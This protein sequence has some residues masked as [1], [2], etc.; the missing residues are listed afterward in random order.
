MITN[1]FWS[2]C[3]LAI[4]ILIIFA[5]FGSSSVGNLGVENEWELWDGAATVRQTNSMNPPEVNLA[6]SVPENIQ[7]N[8]IPQAETNNTGLDQYLYNPIFPIAATQM[9]PIEQGAMPPALIKE[10][11]IEVVENSGGFVKIT[12]VMGNSW[13]EKAGLKSKDIIVDF[14]KEK[15]NGLDHFKTLLSK[16]SPE[17]DYPINLLRGDRIKSCMVTLGEGEMEGFTPIVPAAFNSQQ[18]VGY[19][20]CPNCGINYSNRCPSCNAVLIPAK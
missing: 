12:G 14:N 15:I 10:L 1:Y 13:A 9:I 11:G 8:P 2:L 17:N 20:S 7:I 6:N 18:P 5:L 3:F 16:A 19:Y 4:A